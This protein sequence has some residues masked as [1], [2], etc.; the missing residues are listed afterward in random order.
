MANSDDNKKSGYILLYRSLLDWEWADDPLT[1]ALY[2]RLL[3]K[4]NH[5]DAEWHGIIVKRGQLIT[6]YSNLS[7][8]SGMTYKQIRGS[9]NKL[10]RAGCVA[11]QATPKYGVVTLLNYDAYQSQ[12]SQEGRQRAGKWAG[13]GQSEGSQRATNN[14]YNK[15]NNEN[16]NIPADAPENYEVIPV[17]PRGGKF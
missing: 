16:K 5:A 14:K 7:N 8:E 12:G 4:A 10:K 13:R 17:V 9:L 15:Y 6:S 1:F 3:L 2:V 11:Y